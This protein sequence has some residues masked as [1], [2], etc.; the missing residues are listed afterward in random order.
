[1]SLE[2]QT[3][4][5]HLLIFT[6]FC[7]RFGFYILQTI[8]VLY[9]TKA[10]GAPD[11]QAYF[12][13]GIFSAMLYLAPLL[14]SYIV[15]RYLGLQRAIMMGGVLLAIG[16]LMMAI[17][18]QNS[19]LFGLSM[20]VIGSGLF[21]PLESTA[22]RKILTSSLIP[23]LMTG[24]LVANFGW[25]SNF[26]LAALVI[27]AGTI[28]FFFCRSRL[29]SF[30][31]LPGFSLLHRKEGSLKFHSLFFLGI[32]ATIGILLF[33]FHFPGETVVLTSILTLIFLG[34]TILKE[35]SAKDLILKGISVGA[36]ALYY[37]MFSSL[38]L[39][40]DHCMTK[41]FFG[42][43]IGAPFTLFFNPLFIL[44]L[45]PM[46]RRLR[47]YS[48]GI[49]LM[50]LGFFLLGFG[51]NTS[52]C[53]VGSYLLQT[54]GV[55]LLARLSHLA[56]AAACALGGALAVLSS[57]PA[58]TPP[59]AA[60]KIYQNAF[61]IEGGIALGLFALSLALVPILKRDPILQ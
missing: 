3:R 19:F 42:L 11:V 27:S 58:N 31:G 21:M 29:R 5:S 10:F 52:Y 22:H 20:I 40:A 44:L 46:V 53:L 50:G 23:P 60:L 54:M 2:N 47:K 35:K 49:L 12:L 14:G 57:V 16:Y 18:A 61:F 59:E 1:M 34:I 56:Q 41:E 55:L 48:L 15:D 25:P 13:F 7:G 8:I 30:G 24:T 36:Y 32:L 4:A 51:G 43:Q 28:T 26:L 17:P 6:E 33:L 39:Y 37:Q 45:S 9:M 38:L